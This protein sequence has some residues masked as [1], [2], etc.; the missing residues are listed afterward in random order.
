M[1]PAGYPVIGNVHGV[2]EQVA[3]GT[4][5]AYVDNDLIAHVHANGLLQNHTGR[6]TQHV[7]HP[8]PH[9]VWHFLSATIVDYVRWSYQL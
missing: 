5:V 1:I 2:T 4:R 3:P 7:G 9:R 6:P 8:S